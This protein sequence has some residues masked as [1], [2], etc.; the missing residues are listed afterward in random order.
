MEPEVK[1]FRDEKTLMEEVKTLQARGIHK[2]KLYVITHDSDRTNKIAGDADAHEVGIHEEG[3][4]TAVGNIFRKKD[5]KLRTKFK[6]LE[7]PQDEIN[8]LEEKLEQGKII[9]LIS[10]D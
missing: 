9:L 8:K 4:G 10:N 1:E 6:E 2:D 5:E 7:F 3:L